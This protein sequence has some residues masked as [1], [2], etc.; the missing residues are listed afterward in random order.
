MAATHKRPALQRALQKEWRNEAE[1]DE[2]RDDLLGARIA[3][4][5]LLPLLY[6]ENPKIRGAATKLYLDGA[7]EPRLKALVND[8]CWKTAGERK[9]AGD[10][11]A[12]VPT[13]VMAPIV[14]WAIANDESQV[15]TVGWEVALQVGGSLRAKYLPRVLLEGPRALRLPALQRLAAE[16]D[17]KAI[18]PLLV[19]ACADEDPRVADAAVEAIVRVDDPLVADLMIDAAGHANEAVRQRARRYLLDAARRDPRLLARMMDTLSDADAG[20]RRLGVEI[21]LRGA[22]RAA[23]LT[24][25]ARH[26]RALPGWMRRRLFETL[27]ELGDDVLVP[28]VELL[29]HPEA[30]VRLSA[31][32][33]AEAFLDRRAVEPVCA[34][35]ADPDEQLRVLAC[36]VLGRL[37]DERAVGPLV[38]ALGDERVRWAAVEA[39]ARVGSSQALQPLVKALSDPRKEVRLEVVKAL[40]AFTD[41]R[42]VVVLKRVTEVEPTSEVR[43]R[44]QEVVRD[45][46]RR[47]DLEAAGDERDTAAVALDHLGSLDRLLAIARRMDASDLH[48]AAGEPPYLRIHGRLERVEEGRILESAEIR[49]AVLAIMDEAHHLEVKKRGQAAFC[50]EVPEVGRYR[51]NV[52]RTRRGWSAVFRVIPNMPPTFAAIQAPPHLEEIARYRHGLVVV[53][54][55]VGSGKSSTV[56]AIVNR[57]GETRRA[58]VVTLEEPVEFVHPSKSSLVSQREVPTHTESFAIGLGA[59]LHQDPDVIVVGEMRDAETIRRALAAA[60]RGHL[61][62]ATLPT[63]SAAA[64]IARIVALFPSPEQPRIREALAGSLRAVVAQL[65]VPRKDGEGRIAVFEVL[66]ATPTMAGL[67]RDDK[68]HQIHDLVVAGRDEGMQSRDAALLSL[69]E[70]GAVAAEVAWRRANAPGELE[71][72]CSPEFLAEVAHERPP[73]PERDERVL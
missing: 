21:L 59:A 19:K 4:A 2:L 27:A 55:A 47:L 62:L 67:L 14:D 45:M 16:S 9:V 33:L 49:D 41:K 20:I 31:L 35:L 13:A 18:L 63:S 12:H 25:V 37:C 22:D 54:G 46:A 28:A 42:L 15:A 6:Q 70:A 8:M 50:H 53:A 40:G 52:F 56:A 39:L 44:A 32:L 57:I 43:T 72:F 38:Q 17:P 73:K 34:L 29:R 24:E 68:L 66:R 64:T 65:L 1:L 36:D 51:A 60:Q 26:A 23:V 11:F 58:H 5:Q 10:L 3:P 30:D 69:V 7:D 61:V 71:R 48:L